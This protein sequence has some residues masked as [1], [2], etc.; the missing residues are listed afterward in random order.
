M[1]SKAVKYLQEN[2]ILLF[3]LFVTSICVVYSIT[4]IKS[5]TTTTQTMLEKKLSIIV[6]GINEIKEIEAKTLNLIT[7]HHY[8]VTERYTQLEEDSLD[9]QLYIT[10]NYPRVPVEVAN[11]IAHKVVKLC[12]SHNIDIS[13]VIGMMEVES[14][15]NPFA[16]SKVGALGLMQVMPNVWGKELGIK[17]RSDL[18]DIETGIE[19]GIKVILIYLEKSNNNLTTALQKYNGIVEGSV[20]SNKVYAAMERFE[21]CRGKDNNE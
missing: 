17:S 21:A 9:I 6:K 18:H 2:L 10:M 4:Y 15:F 7:E 20:F 14:S 12:V 16:V 19:T 5:S 3:I 11:I 8:L 13:L 1:L